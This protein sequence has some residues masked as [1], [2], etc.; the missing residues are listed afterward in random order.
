MVPVDSEIDKVF[1]EAVV[2]K[3]MKSMNG[4]YRASIPDPS[5]PTKIARG[6][7]DQGRGANV[8]TGG[9]V[10]HMQATV[11]TSLSIRCEPVNECALRKGDRVMFPERDNETYEVTFIYDDPGG[12]PDVHLVR[13]LEDE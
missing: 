7:Y 13:V 3:P 8:P 6:I 9:G 1:G 12:R 4:G 5:R 10:M 11:D 2:L